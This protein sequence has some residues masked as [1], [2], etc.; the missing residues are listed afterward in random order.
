M[1]GQ[2]RHLRPNNGNG[3]G[4]SSGTGN[5]P[6]TCASTQK[7]DV[8]VVGAGWAGIKTA[9]LLTAYMSY[10]PDF[11]FTVLEKNP[12]WELIGRAISAR[13]LMGGRKNPVAGLLSEQYNGDMTAIDQHKKDVKVV[14][15][16]NGTKADYFD[17]FG[18]V[19]RVL[20][21]IV[22]YLVMLY[23]HASISLIPLIVPLTYSP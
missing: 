17:S 22:E 15:V 10:N 9:E 7:Y 20:A 4:S 13:Y 14:S 21:C 11:K 23:S 18:T 1:T 12:N 8:V 5:R 16:Y 2:K 19:R 6:P 3:S